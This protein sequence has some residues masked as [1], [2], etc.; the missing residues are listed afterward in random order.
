MFDFVKRCLT[1]KTPIVPVAPMTRTLVLLGLCIE[2]SIIDCCL[3]IFSRYYTF[4]V[5][6]KSLRIEKYA[7]NKEN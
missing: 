4:F 1:I 3:R 6:L 5:A 7:I 2:I